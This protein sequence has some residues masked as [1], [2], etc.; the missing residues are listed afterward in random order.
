[1]SIQG[2]SNLKS[3]TGLRSIQSAVGGRPMSGLVDETVAQVVAEDTEQITALQAQLASLQ[4]QLAAAQ[5]ALAQAQAQIVADAATIASLQAQV[6]I[7]QGQVVALQAQLSAF[8]LFKTYFVG[9]VTE[10]GGGIYVPPSYDNPVIFTNIVK[11]PQVL[12]QVTTIGGG[13]P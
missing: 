2:R 8:T 9:S 11:P 6:L 4:A 1:M 7:L 3:K 5:A 12:I 13:Y 10:V